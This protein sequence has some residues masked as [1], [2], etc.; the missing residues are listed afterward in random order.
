MALIIN[1]SNGS[2][3]LFINGQ[4]FGFSRIK[5]VIDSVGGADI[6]A[7]S[8]ISPAFTRGFIS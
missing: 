7:V 5:V 1:A 8:T 2:S 6:I 4:L 3:L